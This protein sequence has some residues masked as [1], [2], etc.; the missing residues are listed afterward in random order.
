M[1]SNIFELPETAWWYCFEDLAKCCNA[2]QCLCTA[3]PASLRALHAWNPEWPVGNGKCSLYQY[4]HFCNALC[5]I[6]Q[7]LQSSLW[8]R[9]RS[10][11][12][13]HLITFKTSVISGVFDWPCSITWN[14]QLWKPKC[15]HVG[16]CSLWIHTSCSKEVAASDTEAV[17]NQ[18]RKHV[19]NSHGIIDIGLQSEMLA[20][21]PA[22]QQHR[23]VRL[24]QNMHFCSDNLPR[25][26]IGN[27]CS[28]SFSV[29]AIPH[30]G[31]MQCMKQRNIDL[32]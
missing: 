24:K 9:K 20:V 2:R 11:I 1:R 28:Y 13:H 23:W 26:N 12:V 25:Y 29:P 10:Y 30:H 5:D 22:E 17:A 27:T 19:W 14:Q 4:L 6:F 32:T 7:Q 8:L 18:K 15:K 3:K 31:C 21:L 16:A